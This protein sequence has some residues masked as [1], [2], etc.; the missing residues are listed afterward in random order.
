MTKVT[1]LTRNVNGLSTTTNQHKLLAWMAVNQVDIAMLQEV[2]LSQAAA[3]RLQDRTGG[4]YQIRSQNYP[5]H[6]NQ[7]GTPPTGT[8]AVI[9]GRNF[10]I[11]NI[12]M[13]NYDPTGSEWLAMV[14]LIQAHP[15][16]GSDHS[17]VKR[18]NP[19]LLKSLEVQRDIEAII[20][21]ATWDPKDLIKCSLKLQQ[22]VTSYFKLSE[23]WA[24]CKDEERRNKLVKDRVKLENKPASNDTKK[25]LKWIKETICNHDNCKMNNYRYNGIAKMR[26]LM[27]RRGREFYQTVSDW[28]LSTHQKIRALKTPDG[29]RI[30][31]LKEILKVTQSFYQKLY[32]AEPTDLNAQNSLLAQIKQRIS[33]QAQKELVATIGKRR[34]AR[35]ISP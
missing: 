8:A 25:R 30:E 35:A 19:A 29:R 6:V 5:E 13:D 7:Q 11:T 23:G 3:M 15:W 21:N 22:M 17:C 16:E 12:L 34:I 10:L 32:R 9:R 28:N 33:T 18:L 14:G 2:L 26:L 20:K 4:G 31:E 1:L 27:S 24:W